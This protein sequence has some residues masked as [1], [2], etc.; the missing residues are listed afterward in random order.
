MSEG[1]EAVAKESREGSDLSSAH[2]IDEMLTL[3][4]QEHTHMINHEDIMAIDI[5]SDLLASGINNNLHG[6]HHLWLSW[7]HWDKVREAIDTSNGH[8]S[9][10][11]SVD[12]FIGE[13]KGK[14]HPRLALKDT[15]TT[16]GQAYIVIG[17]DVGLGEWEPAAS[18]AL[19]ADSSLEFKCERGTLSHWDGSISIDKV[20]VVIGPVRVA[21]ICSDRVNRGVQVSAVS[22]AL[23]GAAIGYDAVVLPVTPVLPHPRDLG[24]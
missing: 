14:V 20:L 2:L 3:A 11:N 12:E 15:E 5:P 23:Q 8:V 13:V 4:F 6:M 21:L 17:V 1:A 24:E 10:I 18:T 9:L 19:S 16:R 22:G 7:A